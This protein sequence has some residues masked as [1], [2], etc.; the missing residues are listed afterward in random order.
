[1]SEHDITQGVIQNNTTKS[2]GN[3]EISC[4]FLKLAVCYASK[5][6]QSILDILTSR[7]YSQTH[8]K[9]L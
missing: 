6:L 3:N 7:K 1:M 2:V 4:Y 9:L 5:S 8:G